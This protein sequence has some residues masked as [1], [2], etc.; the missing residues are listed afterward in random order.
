LLRWIRNEN[1]FKKDRSLRNNIVNIWGQEIMGGIKRIW[2]LGLLIIATV[3][4]QDGSALPVGD[5]RLYD[6]LLDVGFSIGDGSAEV[7]C[8]V[9][10][11]RT[12][13]YAGKY[14]YAYQICNIDSEIGLSFFSVGILDGANAFDA[15]YD[16][17][18]L[19]VVM[20]DQWAV[21]GT[22]AQSVDA[23]FTSPIH[24]DGPITTS[25]VLWFVSDYESTLGS[26]A[27]FGT[28]SGTPYY[29]TGNLLTPVPEPATLV[30][31]GIGGL[32][33]LTRKKRFVSL[34]RKQKKHLS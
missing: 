23:L 5:K 6:S 8:E 32:L 24:S 4:V 18:L 25:T 14:V 2:F 3:F 26:G 10:K 34:V 15:N 20:P 19:D 16:N 22:P 12:G 28:L 29:A 33:I 27:L 17:S 1:H 30:L 11:Y 31:L 21:V 13:P 9:Y 7:D